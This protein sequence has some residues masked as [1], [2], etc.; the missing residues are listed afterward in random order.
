MRPSNLATASFASVLCLCAVLYS[1]SPSSQPSKPS[2]TS[3][4]T[5]SPLSLITVLRV[6]AGSRE[7][8][9]W[10]GFLS[11]AEAKDGTAADW[12][13]RDKL[14]HSL[15][16]IST[17][18]DFT[19]E[20]VVIESLIKEGQRSPRYERVTVFHT[21]NA[22]LSDRLIAAGARP[23]DRDRFTAIGSPASSL[24]K[25]GDRRFV[26]SV[27]HL[28]DVL[29]I[30]RFRRGEQS[31]GAYYNFSA[32]ADFAV[33]KVPCPRAS[34]PDSLGKMADLIDGL[35]AIEVGKDS[36]GDR[37]KQTAALFPLKRS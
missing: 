16:G 33:D 20:I 30:T 13:A 4:P 2:T 23:L 36:F 8:L 11:G 10:A 32:A 31:T 24:L 15:R 6:Q 29:V 22:A 14:I 27:S 37:Y 35:T 34:L 18:K 25:A 7:G 26:E 9:S 1:K 28:I 3:L 5:T 17:E 12:A 21:E 19:A